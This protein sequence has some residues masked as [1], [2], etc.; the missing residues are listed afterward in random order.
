VSSLVTYRL[1]VTAWT[2]GWI[3]ALPLTNSLSDLGLRIDQDE[4]A[5]CAVT[6]L[7]GHSLIWFDTGADAWAWLSGHD[8]LLSLWAP[9]DLTIGF[10]VDRSAALSEQARTEIDLSIELHSP[11]GDREDEKAIA[12]AESV[13]V[14][15]LNESELIRAI[16]YD[17]EMY[18]QMNLESSG[19]EARSGL[20][21][22]MGYWN[23]ISR[24]ECSHEVVQRLL[25]LGGWSETRATAVIVSFATWPWQC[26]SA[27]PPRIRELL[28]P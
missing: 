12:L 1:V 3:G 25:D 19:T 23:A 24:R 11:D 13:A 21:E 28:S 6:S 7:D 26:R 18:E 17:E 10:S 2:T 20:P 27:L 16:A 15:I 14:A 8:G 4:A 5:P 9:D 22:I